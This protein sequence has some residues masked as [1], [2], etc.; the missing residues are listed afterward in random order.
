MGDYVKHSIYSELG[1]LSRKAVD[2]M[3]TEERWQKLAQLLAV[4]LR[5][6]VNETDN[7]SKLKEVQN[8]H[9]IS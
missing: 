1:D 5:R 9:G 8:G 6:Q 7:E 4:E 2:L 3:T